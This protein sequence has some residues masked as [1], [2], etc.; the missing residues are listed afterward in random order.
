MPLLKINMSWFSNFGGRKPRELPVQLFWYCLREINGYVQYLP[1][2]ELAFTEPQ[3]QQA[4]YNAMPNAWKEC[5]INAQWHDT[6]INKRHC[7][8]KKCWITSISNDCKERKEICLNVPVPV[9]PSR[10]SPKRITNPVSLVRTTTPLVS[11]RNALVN[12]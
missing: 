9:H 10:P 1:G 11:L 2:T 7:L 6:F 12:P 3:I 5:Y 8:I 4:F